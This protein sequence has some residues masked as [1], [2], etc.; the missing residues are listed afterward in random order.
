MF[1]PLIGCGD[2]ESSIDPSSPP[3]AASG[4]VPST[5]DTPELVSPGAAFPTDSATGSNPASKSLTG[6]PPTTE[7]GTTEPTQLSMA[8]SQAGSNPQPLLRPNLSPEGLR[9]F[10]SDVDYNLRLLSSGKSGITDAKKSRARLIEYINLKLEASRQLANHAEASPEEKSEGTR[11]ELQAMSHLASLGNVKVAEQLEQTATEYLTSDDPSLVSDS[12]LVLVG[13][14]LE[15]LNGGDEDAPNTIVAYF[16]Q[17]RTS[18][19]K[20]DVPTLMIMGMAREDLA[21]A[22]YDSQAQKVR[23]MILEL[24]ADSPEPAIAEMAAQLAGNVTFDAI[25]VQR[26]S[27]VNGGDL[28]P[29]QWKES[30]STL[31]AES[32]DLQTVQYLAGAAVE[33]E[34]L[35][36]EDLVEVTYQALTDAFTDS[37]SAAAKEIR[38]AKNARQ[39]R[40]DV[41]G[42]T[43]TWQLP[44]TDGTPLPLSNFNGKVV[45]MPFWA[46]GFPPSL[47]IVPKLSAIRDAHPDKV[48]IV[49][50]NLDPE[51][52]DVQSFI[53]QSQLG[54][55]SLR[56]ESS[57]TA[58]VAN[59]MAADFGMVSLPFVAILDGKGKVHSLNFTGQNL[60]DTVN[61]LL[62]Q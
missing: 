60:E 32:A 34:G 49:G 2:R 22:G 9:S 41:I 62:E 17:L 23:K 54:F 42:K 39:A 12:R 16:D 43:F 4:G 47:S 5:S 13:F 61:S 44:K 52:A 19:S 38:I 3:Y 51:G 55:P 11:G 20:P 36:R 56:C 40:Q 10:L 25:E 7:S 33:L 35:E 1:L 27:L 48:A 24:F 46:M 21:A 26:A 8:E 15:A 57:P 18:Q 6:S 53:N 29:Q 14:A 45:L 28:T 58:A 30:V 50:V 59:Q 37:N 31:I